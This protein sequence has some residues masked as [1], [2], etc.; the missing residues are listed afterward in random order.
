MGSF[1][2]RGDVGGWNYGESDHANVG[3]ISLARNA[4]PCLGLNLAKDLL[5]HNIILEIDCSPLVQKL[6]GS[7]LDVLTLGILSKGCG[8]TQQ[9]LAIKVVYNPRNLNVL[10]HML[11]QMACGIEEYLVWIEEAQCD[12]NLT[13]MAGSIIAQ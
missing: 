9:I 8:R 11:V 10:V 2:H 5:F 4:S 7:S 3:D 6:Q 12:V 1:E 13:I